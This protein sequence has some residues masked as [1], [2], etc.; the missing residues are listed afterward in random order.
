[1]VF[2]REN[3]KRTREKKLEKML[4]KKIVGVKQYENSSQSAREK[5][6]TTVKFFKI[7]TLENKIDAHEKFNKIYPWKGISSLKSAAV[8]PNFQPVKK[9]E[10]SAREKI[11]GREISPII[12]KLR[13]WNAKNALKKKSKNGQKCVSRVLFKWWIFLQKVLGSDDISTFIT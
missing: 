8:K 7:S 1:M 13:T 2:F 12:E 10:K 11:S 3:K 4:V 6:N 9:M 5:E